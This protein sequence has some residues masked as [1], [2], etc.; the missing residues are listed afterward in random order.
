[1]AT[2]N[3]NL[4]VGARLVARYKGETYTA[5]VVNSDGGGRYRLAD[6]REFK[7]P[8]AAGSAVM[9]G[10]ACNGWRFWSLA[11]ELA[12]KAAVP[13]KK[14]ETKK[15][16]LVERWRCLY[17]LHI[18]KTEKAAVA[19]RCAGA[20]AAHEN[21]GGSTYETVTV[22]PMNAINASSEKTETVEVTPEPAEETAPVTADAA[23]EPVE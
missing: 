10:M 2:E 21:G 1:M 6:G 12:E 8:S 23:E 15:N 11:D 4:A 20:R 5:E 9:G 22:D 18:Y 14:P 16:G 3:R 17:C 13:D 7:S 19:C